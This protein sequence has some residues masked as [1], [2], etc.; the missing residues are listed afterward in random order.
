M[1]GSTIASPLPKHH[2]SDRHV[3]LDRQLSA[4]ALCVYRMLR[5]RHYQVYGSR[6]VSRQRRRSRA[7]SASPTRQSR[8]HLAAGYSPSSRPGSAMDHHPER[9]LQLCHLRLL[10][11]SS[12]HLYQTF[13][14]TSPCPST[15]HPP[16]R[17]PRRRSSQ[18]SRRSPCSPP[19]S[20]WQRNWTR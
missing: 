5:L 14:R 12:R 8:L 9:S 2:P 1:T 16:C 18:L 17:S 20:F 3:S 13:T 10:L 19:R 7:T 6:G 4:A 11:P 15:A